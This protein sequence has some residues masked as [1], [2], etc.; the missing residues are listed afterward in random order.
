M[1]PKQTPAHQ[2]KYS[3][4]LVTLLLLLSL[5]LL[6]CTPSLD[7]F[8]SLA[9]QGILPLSNENPHLGANLFL[10][11]EA[12]RS[13]YLI[14]FLKKRGGP[15]AIEVLTESRLKPSLL[16]FYP[17][18]QEVY[19]ADLDNNE[20]N[21]QWIVRG[22]YMMER[23]DYRDLNGMGIS[24]AAEPVFMIEGQQTRFGIKPIETAARALL[25]VVPTPRPTAKPRKSSYG[26]H[27]A[28]IAIPTPFRP[29]NSDQQAIAL[30]EGF[31]ERSEN[32]DLIHQVIND[33]ESLEKISRW[34]T[35]TPG[36]QN[37]IAQANAITAGTPLTIGTRVRIPFSLVKQFK[38][39]PK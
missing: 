4:K 24:F 6:S 13:S 2:I 19:V 25:P 23:H 37:S 1:L 14:N 3:I 16:L 30:S 7:K 31:A 28:V 33:G 8:D 27:A 15:S 12:Q 5:T 34:Y 18:K 20:V 9:N 11:Q 21:Y 10:A 32:G 36:N 39:M 38:S 17:L 26:N 29:L 35:G 22:P